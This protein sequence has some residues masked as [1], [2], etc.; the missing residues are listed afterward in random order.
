MAD[1]P[2]EVK[3]S[4]PECEIVEWGLHSIAEP[5]PWIIFVQCLNSGHISYDRVSDVV[6]NGVSFASKILTHNRMH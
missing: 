5:T 6:E 1:P 4:C 3:S 2:G